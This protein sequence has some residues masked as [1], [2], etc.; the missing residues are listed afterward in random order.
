MSIYS[1]P[2][3]S[4]VYANYDKYNHGGYQEQ[5][6]PDYDSTTNEDY[7]SPV[8]PTYSESKHENLVESEHH[9]N[10]QNQQ[11]GHDDSRHKLDHKK[12]T[13]VPV[14]VSNNIEYKN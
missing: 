7:E 5:G 13:Y 1:E 12:Y 2:P 4:H 3:P 6:Q 8:P 10:P 11:Y 14:Y 9:A